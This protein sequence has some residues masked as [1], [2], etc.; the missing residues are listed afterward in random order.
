MPLLKVHSPS[1]LHFHIL[2]GLPKYLRTKSIMRGV[3]GELP[4]RSLSSSTSQLRVAMA[5]TLRATLNLFVLFLFWFLLAM[6]SSDSL[7]PNSAVCFLLIYATQTIGLLRPTS[8]VARVACGVWR[9]FV[10]LSVS[11]SWVFWRPSHLYMFGSESF[12]LSF[13]RVYTNLFSS[14]LKFSHFWNTFR[15]WK[16]PFVTTLCLPKY[17]WDVP[18]VLLF[19]LWV[20]SWL[21]KG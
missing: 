3:Q 12:S 2:L 1:C 11:Q 10:V 18:W 17:L 14:V 21:C 15:E 19:L 9:P 20:L 16:W 13:L 5:S 4:W 6:A 7:Q 8:C